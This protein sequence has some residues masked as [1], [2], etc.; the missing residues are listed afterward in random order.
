[1]EIVFRARL[2]C[3]ALALAALFAPAASA[4]PRLLEA[5]MARDPANLAVLTTSTP[6][7]VYTLMGR[8]AP[9]GSGGAEAAAHRFLD[10]YGELVGMPPGGGSRDALKVIATRTSAGGTTLVLAPVIDELVFQESQLALRFHPDGELIA[11]TGGYT[12]PPP[13]VRPAVDAAGAVRVALADARTRAEPGAHLSADGAVHEALYVAPDAKLH[14]LYTIEVSVTGSNA[15]REV[16]VDGSGELLGSRPLRADVAS[17]GIE[18]TGEARAM[19][20]DWRGIPYARQFELRTRGTVL[21]E[22][23]APADPGTSWSLVGEHIKSATAQPYQA[24][25]R[26]GLFDFEPVITVTRWDGKPERRYNPRFLDTH[27]YECLVRAH[28]FARDHGADALADAELEYDAVDSLTT[29]NAG[30]EPLENRISC[31]RDSPILGGCTAMDPSALWHEFGHYVMW[32]VSAEF[33]NSSVLVRTRDWRKRWDT[34]QLAAVSEGFADFFS[35]SMAASQGLAVPHV[36]AQESCRSCVGGTRTCAN[37]ARF[38]DDYFDEEHASGMIISGLLWSL[39]ER[40]EIGPDLAIRLAIQAMHDCPFYM[41]FFGYVIA[42]RMTVAALRDPAKLA[43]FEAVCR[44][45]G[46]DLHGPE[47]WT[48]GSRVPK[49]RPPGYNVC[50]NVMSPRHIG[51]DG[52]PRVPVVPGGAR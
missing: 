29:D 7:P 32:Y 52:H 48:W 27:V 1:M 14:R 43:A 3:R 4:N 38:P 12:R 28:R 22:L 8:L 23:K 15:S 2:A 31:S 36:I 51:S 45:R 35:A 18:E 25:S 6:A 5:L 11:V 10:E 17:S 42:L 49:P 24:R 46:L 26:S 39:R 47:P 20:V 30:Y 34:P 40:P 37:S 13:A 19:S 33:R 41:D 50:A 44:A 16:L 9:P 21:P